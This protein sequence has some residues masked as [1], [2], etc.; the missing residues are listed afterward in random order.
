[1]E[2]LGVL[3]DCYGIAMELLG[4]LGVCQGVARCSK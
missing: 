3:G 2:L 4:V 1:M